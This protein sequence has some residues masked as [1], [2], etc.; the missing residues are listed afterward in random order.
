MMLK[1]DSCWSI[2]LLDRISIYLKSYISRNYLSSSSSSFS[3]FF[4]NSTLLASSSTFFFSIASSLWSTK[5]F[6]ALP[7]SSF[8]FIYPVGTNVSFEIFEFLS[9]DSSFLFRSFSYIAYLAVRIGGFWLSKLLDSVCDLTGLAF[10]PL[11][12]L[13]TVAGRDWRP[14]KSTFVSVV[15]RFRALVGRDFYLTGI[16]FTR[17]GPYY[18]IGAASLTTLNAFSSSNG[19]LIVSP[20][21]LSHFIFTS[22]TSFFFGSTA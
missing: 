12:E 13:W 1:S 21:D 8:T 2:S 14:P 10:V 4:Y 22:V 6:L 7:C 19:F 17:G 20:S 3:Y 9:S 11:G 15:T 18:I 5:V 16:T